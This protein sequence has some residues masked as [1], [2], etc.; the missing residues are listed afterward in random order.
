MSDKKKLRILIADDELHIRKML[1]MTMVSMGAE[2]VGE[3]TNG[4]EAVELF[5]KTR[6][7]IM[8]LDVN[9]PLMTGDE[10]LLEI[11]SEF[12]DA[13]IIMMTSVAHSETVQKCIDAG[14][15]TYIL[16]DTPLAEMKS[17]IAETW[18]EFRAAKK[19]SV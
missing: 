5:R 17:M 6:P 19:S 7:H 14:A 10:V 11:K 18:K 3:A 15:A 8:L 9:M 4:K 12:P 2:I 13:F 16:K 1:N